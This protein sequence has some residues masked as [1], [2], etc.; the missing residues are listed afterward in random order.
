MSNLLLV[1]DA[2]A[3]IGVLPSG[4]DASAEDGALALRVAG[5]MVEEW[6]DD[7]IIVNWPAQPELNDECELTGVEKTSVKQQLAVR[8]CPFFGCD[9]PATLV[10]LAQSSYA[11]LRRIQMVARLEPVVLSLPAA[12]GSYGTFSI[13]DG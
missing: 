7:G 5:E 2:L 13:V 1:N 12:E 8:L 3:L 9:P 6:A 10:A 4:V 11:K